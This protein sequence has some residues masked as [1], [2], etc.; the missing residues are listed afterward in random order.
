MQQRDGMGE[1]GESYIVDSDNRLRSDSF[2]DPIGRSV[3]ASF[4]GTIEQNGVDTLAVQQGLMGIS[5]TQII[6]D[7]NDNA[8]RPALMPINFANLNWVLISEI[9][10]AEAFAATDRMKSSILMVSLL[11]LIVVC[12]SALKITRSILLPIGGEPKTMHQLAMRIADGDLTYDFKDNDNAH[13]L[14]KS[15]KQMNQSLLRVISSII[16]SSSQL[17]HTVEQTSATSLQAKASLAEQHLNIETVSSSMHEMAMTIEEV[18]NNA[19]DSSEQTQL[20]KIKS[21][22]ANDD[23]NAALVATEELKAALASANLV[24][25]QVEKKS[26]G[27]NSVLEVI[28]GITEQTNLLALNAAIEAARA[29]E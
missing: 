26:L 21:T 13:G 2:L 24:I 17:S 9:D 5:S 14:F 27:I 23:I 8:I 25:K 18:A 4:A 16:S 12:I 11:T 3:Q 7:Y 20:A 6:Q 10:V 28:Q 1:T 19:K 29:G 22:Q 15:M